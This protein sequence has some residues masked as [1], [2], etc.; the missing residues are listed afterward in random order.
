MRPEVIGPEVREP[1]V[2][3]PMVAVFDLRS[4]LDARPDTYREVVV[5]FRAE[6][7]VDEAVVEKIEVV[8]ALVVVEFKPVKF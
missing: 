7:L 3:V 5:A 1:V 8:V 2:R 4:V 6:S